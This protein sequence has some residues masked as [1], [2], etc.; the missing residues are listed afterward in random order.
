MAAFKG[1]TERGRGKKKEKKRPPDFTKPG[2]GERVVAADL[3]LLKDSSLQG[4]EFQ[5]S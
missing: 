5:K 1:D 2:A 4:Q 3:A